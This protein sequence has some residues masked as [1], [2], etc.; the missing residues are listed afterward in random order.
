MRRRIQCRTWGRSLRSKKTSDDGM[1]EYSTHSIYDLN[2]YKHG[3][4]DSSSIWRSNWAKSFLG[5][6]SPISSDGGVLMLKKAKSF[7]SET[8][9]LTSVSSLRYFSVLGMSSSSLEAYSTSR[10]NSLLL[11]CLISSSSLSSFG[12]V[13]THP[14]YFSNLILSP[15]Y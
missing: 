8:G 9:I 2:R 3:D 5:R 1:Y 6:I 7:G 15:N 11:F 12:F 14:I 10:F 13:F 4:Q